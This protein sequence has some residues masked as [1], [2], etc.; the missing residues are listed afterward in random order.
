MTKTAEL[1]KKGKSPAFARAAGRPASPALKPVP[2]F[3]SDAGERAFREAN[4]STDHLDRAGA[5]AVHLPNLKPTSKSTSLR[6]PIGRLEALR[7]EANRRDV[8]CQS[9]IKRW[10]SERVEKKSLL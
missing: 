10:L 9:L 7:I 5:K 1:G 4:D 2:A 6:L 3:A 8:P